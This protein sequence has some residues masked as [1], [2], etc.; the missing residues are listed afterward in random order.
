VEFGFRVTHDAAQTQVEIGGRT[1]RKASEHRSVSYEF[2]GMCLGFDPD[3]PAKSLHHDSIAFRHVEETI[4]DRLRS[5]P[6]LEFSEEI[7]RGSL[8]NCCH[9]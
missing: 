7:L 6:L 8:V 3:E 4:T 2:D 9:F 1:A 5:T